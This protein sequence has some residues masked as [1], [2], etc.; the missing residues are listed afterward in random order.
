MDK[1]ELLLLVEEYKDIDKNKYTEESFNEYKKV[2]AIANELINDEDAT[3]E[4]VNSIISFIKRKIYLLE[5]DY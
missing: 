4:E 2:L 3:E 5:E 1:T